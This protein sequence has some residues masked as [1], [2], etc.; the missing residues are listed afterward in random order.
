MDNIESERTNLPSEVSVHDIS[1]VHDNVEHPNHYCQGGIECI[2]AINA[3]MSP[4]GFQDYCKGNVIKYLWRWRD[5][6][7]IED[8]YKAK[9]YLGW[10]IESAED[11]SFVANL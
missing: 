7:G 10:L 3:S 6:G 11:C 5:K 1:A 8:L 2:E 4:D 9:V